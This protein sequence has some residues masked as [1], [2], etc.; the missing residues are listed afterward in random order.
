M[1]YA[2]F[3]LSKKGPLARIWLAAHWDKK[4][5]KAHVFETN[6]ESSVEGILQPKVKMALRT[7]GHLLLGVVRIY[8]RKAKYLLAD[9]NEAFI[10]IKMAFRPGVVDLPEEN[11]EAAV[12]TITLPEVFHDFDT[13]MPDL[14]DIDVSA[15]F[16]LN[17]SRAEE[18]TMREDYGNITLVGDDGF[19]DMGFEDAEIGREGSNMDDALDQA[20]L[21]FGDK[22]DKDEGQSVTSSH[23]TANHSLDKNVNMELDAPLRD[24]G[25]GGDVGEG[26]LSAEAGGLFEPGG[27][28][29]D[30][31]MEHVS[32]D[33][34]SAERIT[35]SEKNDDKKGAAAADSDDDDFF[36]NGGPASMGGGS[37]GPSTPASPQ[38]PIENGAEV[39]D[40]K[41]DDVCVPDQTVLIQNEEETFALAPLDAA[42]TQGIEKSKTKRKRKLIV[43]EVK[44]ISGEEMKSQLSDT[45]DI[46]T[47]LDLAP[48]TK[49]LMHWKET[50]GVEKLFALPGRPIPS[51]VL[52]RL[53]QRH[54]TTR[55]VENEDF[56]LMP[57]E[58]NLDLDQS[59]REREE[60]L[61][62]TP[63]QPQQ[64]QQ[65][66]QLQQTPI[67]ALPLQ[68]TP[69]VMEPVITT[70][71]VTK[72]PSR[73]RK[74]RHEPDH[75]PVMAIEHPLVNPFDNSLQQ[76][77]M[78]MSSTQLPNIADPH[79]MANDLSHLH[80]EVPQMINTP[81]M[82]SQMISPN[83]I[84]PVQAM[85]MPQTP[86]MTSDQQFLMPPPESIQMQQPI[87]Q[88]HDMLNNSQIPE[89][90]EQV[91]DKEDA[92]NQQ[93]ADNFLR[94][95][96]TPFNIQEEEDDMEC[97]ASVG[98]PDE[99][100]A[101]ET[102]E[103]FEER[104]LNKR[105]QQM[106]HVVK[107]RLCKQSDVKFVELVR[108]NNRKQVAQK[109]YTLLVLK[110]QQV[111]EL[112]QEIAFGDIIITG[113]P[114]IDTIY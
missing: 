12:A 111:V 78:H 101:D 88:P 33:N 71:P 45:T 81:A 110:K 97:P 94:P 13:A 52:S 92:F 59:E 100:G 63:Q 85:S 14:N 83:H 22:K 10:K 67:P 34:N 29:D 8:S 25:F 98:P 3:V 23:N 91:F 104:V 114:K 64:P 19:G 86:C 11:R 38:A 47:T 113:G 76:Y 99:Q 53:Y 41:A 26:L 75:R 27:L 106:F 61:V 103:Q 15:Q 36:G 49:R 90:N 16:T 69:L 30:A 77:Q 95:Q 60:E 40:N 43:D 44:N 62:H 84:S 54:L 6:I 5:T 50:G 32:L 96:P 82:Q 93:E 1:F 72:T 87:I 2:H 65:S 7:S 112:T 105:A 4:L 108:A 21:L 39:V 57:D 107:S 74:R 37:S 28:F 55:A 70:P 42:T 24:D 18:I 20:G 89:E 102:Y 46:V 73:P 17:Q 58:E 79:Q 68:N 48:P 35:M 9:C 51:R 56:G 80:H 109:F 31:P 66:P